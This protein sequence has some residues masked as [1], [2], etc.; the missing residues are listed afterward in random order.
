MTDLTADEQE[1]VRV[2]LR[3]MRY[4]AKR[5]SI[6]AKAL[7]FTRKGIMNVAC[8]IKVVSPKT[9]FRV[10]KFVGV[11]FHELLAGKYPPPGT[12]PKC[13]YCAATGCD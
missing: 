4:R 10:A 9:A 5:W 8:G 13:G 6:V 11:S 2:A 7:G 3:A 12:C 1:R